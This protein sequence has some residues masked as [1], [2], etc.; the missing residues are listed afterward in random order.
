MHNEI[1]R[2]YSL[3]QELSWEFG[4][5]SFDTVCCGSL[6]YME[7]MTLK[8]IHSHREIPVLN[9]AEEMGMT[10]GGVSKV[11]D[12]LERKGYAA[13][14][15][16]RSDGRVCCVVPAQGAETVLE[17]AAEQ[18]TRILHRALDHADPGDIT[19]ALKA[20]E[21]LSQALRSSNRKEQSHGRTC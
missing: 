16:N 8:R 5:S 20:L 4:S 17:Q 1:H 9:L 7:F 18:Y 2:L 15:K 11:V 21:F 13:R 19:A 6:T 3:L 10:K 14:V 12:R